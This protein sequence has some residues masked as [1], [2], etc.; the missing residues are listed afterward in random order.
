[1]EVVVKLIRVRGAKDDYDILTIHKQ[2]SENLAG[3][4]FSDKHLM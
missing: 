3:L 2:K 1:M 4:I